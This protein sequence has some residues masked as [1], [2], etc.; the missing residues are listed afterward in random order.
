MK[1][2]IAG[3]RN[4]PEDLESYKILLET[5]KLSGY[6]ITDVVCGKARGVDSLG[7]KYARVSNLGL[8]EMPADWNKHG[9]AAGPIRNAEMAKIA[10]AAIVLWDGSSPGSKNMIQQMN[11]LGKPCYIRIVE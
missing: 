8:I 9:K 1:V 10:D 6:T 5:I 3:S 2:V 11:K 4:F 7:E